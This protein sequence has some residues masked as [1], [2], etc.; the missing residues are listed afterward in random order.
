MS[1]LTCA[2]HTLFLTLLVLGTQTSEPAR[3][4]V[5]NKATGDLK[6]NDSPD[7]CYSFYLSG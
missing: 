5:E 1:R 2:L 4:L 3:R 6:H 7:N